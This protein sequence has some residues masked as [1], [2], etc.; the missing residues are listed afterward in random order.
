MHRPRTYAEAVDY[1]RLHEDHLNS[2]R[3]SRT[4]NRRMGAAIPENKMGGASEGKTLH[5]APRKF[6][7]GVRRLPWDEMQKRREQGLCFN[8]DEKFTPGH[9]CKTKQAFLIEPIE[10]SDEGENEEFHEID[11][12][13]VSVHAM[14]DVKGPRTM[15]LGSWIKGRR[16]IVLIDN[17]SSHNFLNQRIARKLNIQATKVE[18]FNV[19]VA[20][21]EKLHCDTL[22][23][24]VPI[25]IQ[26]VTIRA[27]LY[28]IPLGGLDVV[29]GIQWLEELGEVVTDYK[30]GTMR[31]QWG[32]GLVT[33]KSSTDDQLREV[34]L[35]SIT[36]MWRKGG[37]CYSL[38]IE[39]TIPTDKP[40]NS[41]WHADINKILTDYSI[42]LSSPQEL[43]PKRSFDHHIPLKDEGQAISVHPY[44]YAHFQKEEIK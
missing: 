10:S 9:R 12:A 38:K 18:P 7:S 24:A 22:Y 31:F 30:A 2:K 23:K 11:E 28:V 33:L 25:R 40:E 16:V 8:C 37:Q 26:G 5:N 42:V 3:G 4:D 32:D 43:P 19:K 27:D 41:K 29:L 15:R 34:G 17:G 20:N 36:R 39:P 1:A 21:G 6:P 14:A 44:R 13:E 35:Q